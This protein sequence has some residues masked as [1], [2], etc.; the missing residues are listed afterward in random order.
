MPILQTDTEI[1]RPGN[2]SAALGDDREKTWICLDCTSSFDR[3]EEIVKHMHSENHMVM[4]NSSFRAAIEIPQAEIRNM[5]A[6]FI[7]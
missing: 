7:V 5:L 3:H 1:I 6:A 4:I 2:G